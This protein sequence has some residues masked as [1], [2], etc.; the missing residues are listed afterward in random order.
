MILLKIPICFQF[1][2]G[3]PIWIFLK[4]ANSLHFMTLKDQSQNKKVFQIIVW[5]PIYKG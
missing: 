4:T 5:Y 1:Q 3:W 2:H